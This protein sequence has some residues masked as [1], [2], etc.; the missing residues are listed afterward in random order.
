MNPPLERNPASLNAP[1]WGVAVFALLLIGIVWLF[2]F[3]QLRDSREQALAMQSTALVNLSFIV[4]ENLEQVLDRAKTLRILVQGFQQDAQL[5]VNSDMSAV[6]L[7]DPVF[8]RLSLYDDLGHLRYSTSPGTLTYL[9]SEWR[10]PDARGSGDLW[11]LPRS[12]W[13][14]PWSMPLLMPYTADTGSQHS[15]LLLELDLGYLLRLYQNLDLGAQASIHILTSTGDELSQVDQSGLVMAKGNFDNSVILRTRLRHGQLTALDRERGQPF[16]SFFYH[17]ESFPFVVVVR[18]AESEILAPYREQRSIYIFTVLMLSL[19]V[20]IGLGWLLWMMHGRE[21]H[22]RAL[23]HS[24]QRSQALLE[25]LQRE[26]RKTLEAASRDALTG[27]YNRRLF[28]ELAHS[29]LLGAKRQG[30]FAAVV[31]I[32]LD[33]FKSINDTLGHKVGDQLLQSVSRRLNNTLRES[34]IISRFGG[35]EFVLMLTG[36]R[37]REDIEH[38]AGEL[39]SALSAPYDEL[40]G[41]GLSTSPSIGIALSPQDGM[42]IDTLVKHADIAMYT[43]KR[44][45]RGRYA[46]FDAALN[47]QELNAA[48]LEQ[49]LPGVLEQQLRIHLQPR[50]SLPG[51]QLCGFEALVRWDH[52]EFGLLPPSQLLPLTE[53]LGLMPALTRQV[54]E[55]ACEQLMQWLAEQVPMVPVALNVSLSMLNGPELSRQLK[56]AIER[57]EID[58]AWLE[59]EVNERDLKQLGAEHLGQ[60]HELREFGI[61]LTLDD[62]GS[63]GLDPEEIRRLPFSR[64]KLD[65]SFIRDIRNSFDDNVL[66]SAT[67]SV[68]QRLGLKVAA[69]GVETPDQLVYLKLAGCDEVQGHLFSRALN[70]EEVQQYRQ[71]P[72][73][74]LVV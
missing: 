44:A 49:Q 12:A 52:P 32:D 29:H 18:Q 7:S 14:H 35:D 9:E 4:A 43:A 31:F 50:L 62:F 57:Y 27:L 40:Q 64:I 48:D 56:A 53:S 19:V 20:L 33:R 21:T 36:V 60:L 24:E 30:R 16:A 39:V 51:Y 2:T 23:Q 25:R 15:F 13:Q 65:R 34:D 58:P 26:H 45:G 1:Q 3:I 67:I 59:L 69:K 72:E 37:R 8:N 28:L 22:L 55:Q 54:L 5:R 73:Q 71:Q 61:G 11:V 68:A 47:H 66:L 6:I 17:L 70:A 46:F 63:S 38:R 42:E 10:Y 41:S 74:E